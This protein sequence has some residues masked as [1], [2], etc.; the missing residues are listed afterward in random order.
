MNIKRHINRFRAW[1]RKPI[2][3]SDQGLEEH[4]CANCG[5][6]YSGNYC[7]VCGQKAGDK[8]ITW[9]LVGQ[10]F[11]KAWGIDSSSL[12]STLLQL[13]L[14]PGYLI[15]D[16]LDGHRR[17]SYPP[18]N[19]L[20][21]VTVV[22]LIITQMFGI[23]RTEHFTY[24]DVPEKYAIVVDIMNWFIDNPAWGLLTFTLTFCIQT[25][26][27]FRFAPRHTRHT[28]AEG[29]FIQIYMATISIICTF[30]SNIFTN[31]IGL[32][33]I[34]V[35]AYYY[36]TY[37]QLFGYRFWG[38]LWRMLLAIAVAFFLII[39][40]MAIMVTI[41]RDEKIETLPSLLRPII[42]I[43]VLLAA[44]Y[45]ISRWTAKNRGTA[46]DNRN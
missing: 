38:T 4:C 16:Y 10:N 6:T 3:F 44:G 27:F 26:F 29:V 37:R 21:V 19:M 28:L 12:P 40:I 25:W 45:F 9:R 14:R 33:I 17:V 32:F 46:K 8:H 15:G 23:S 5:H 42:I 18:V 24:S 36:V 11:L 39:L 20:F 34:L 2:Q 7:P 41:W 31:V 43:A 22:Y 13:I 1:Q 30:I 35:A